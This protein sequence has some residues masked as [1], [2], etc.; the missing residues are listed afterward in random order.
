MHI[1]KIASFIAICLLSLNSFAIDKETLKKF[2]Q[3][4]N[5]S[6][7]IIQYK[8]VD[9]ILDAAVLYVGKSSRQKAR[10][11]KQNIGTR[12]KNKK[13]RLTAL[14]GNR[15]FYEEFKTPEKVNLITKIRK[16]L[17]QLP[18]DSP[19]ALFSKKEQLAYWLNLYNMTLLEQ[20]IGLYPTRSLESDIEDSDLFTKQR[21][22]IAGSKLSL[23]DIKEIVIHNFGHDPLLIY[24]FHE[25]NIASPDIRKF[26]YTGKNVWRTLEENA[27]FFIN[28]N[29]GTYSKSASTFRTSYL[30]EKNKAFFPEEDDLKNHLSKFLLRSY[31]DKLLAASKI[32]TDITDWAFAD[33]YGSKRR[34]G[35]SA[36]TSSAA[37]MG[38]FVSSPREGGV[39]PE[40][41]QTNGYVDS[42]SFDS[43]VNDVSPFQ[44]L[45]AL[46]KSDLIE[47]LKTRE[48]RQGTVTVQDLE[49]EE[50]K[51]GRDNE[52][53]N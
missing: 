9:L 27:D 41:A 2:S 50:Q 10:K 36:S 37:L 33:L 26:A 24:G 32:R 14:E 19:L 20:L 18:T 44:R 40:G 13:K 48:I 35:G 52:N 45:S 6:N 28:S 3:Y 1:V 7:Y 43:Q 17:E 46:H 53:N 16:S 8:D 25:G 15:F 23:N 12:F 5:S 38:A 51:S 47:K 39:S 29:R 21:L 22:T 30:Y 11:S 42:G 4:D 31:N 34:F 49:S